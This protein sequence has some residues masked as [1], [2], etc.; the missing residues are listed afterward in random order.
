MITFATHPAAWKRVREGKR[1]RRDKEMKNE[2][3][4]GGKQM[5][6]RKIQFEKDLKGTDGRGE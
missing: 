2:K 4:R 5:M 3:W 6:D 1:R